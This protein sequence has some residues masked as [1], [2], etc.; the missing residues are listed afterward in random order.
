MRRDKRWIYIGILSLVVA[1][2]WIA[3]S[4]IS[5]LRQSTIPADVEKVATPLSP[6]LDRSIFTSLSKRQ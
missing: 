4:A 2:C 5:R 3:V 1:I 6:D